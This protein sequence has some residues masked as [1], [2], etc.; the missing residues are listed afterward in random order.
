MSNNISHAQNISKIK[1]YDFCTVYDPEIPLLWTY[2][3]AMH[4]HTHTNT[5]KTRDIDQKIH[6]NINFNF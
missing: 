2:P 3:K 6:C 4:T 5:P 1:M